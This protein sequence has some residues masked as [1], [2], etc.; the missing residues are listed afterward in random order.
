MTELQT[1]EGLDDAHRGAGFSCQLG[2]AEQRH[3]KG[4]LSNLSSIS[5]SLHREWSQLQQVHDEASDLIYRGLLPKTCPCTTQADIRKVTENGKCHSQSA[6]S[7]GSS[8]WQ[9]C[10][11]GLE[12]ADSL[13]VGSKA[14]PAAGLAQTPSSRGSSSLSSSTNSLRPLLDLWKR[15]HLS[16][17]ALREY[18]GDIEL[19]KFF[20]VSAASGALAQWRSTLASRCTFS[21]WPSTPTASWTSPGV[22][23]LP[24]SPRVTR[25]RQA[26]ET[27]WR[28]SQLD[29]P[30]VVVARRAEETGSKSVIPVTE[31]AS[32][33]AGS[34]CGTC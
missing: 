10:F 8:F 34:Y 2:N 33:V 17:G 28:P 24:K 18:T 22:H 30:R 5:L 11:D 26:E 6:H 23:S 16:R 15:R 25:T 13:R 32:E 3:A 12:A 21:S 19:D 31:H 9:K 1:L 29:S 7:F 27:G 4:V 20:A 14:W